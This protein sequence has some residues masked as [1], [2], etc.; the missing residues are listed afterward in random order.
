MNPFHNQEHQQKAAAEKTKPCSLTLH[1][2]QIRELTITFD[3]LSKRVKYGYVYTSFCLSSH[4]FCQY[5]L[6]G[7]DLWCFIH[8]PSWILATLPHVAIAMSCLWTEMVAICPAVASPLDC[9]CPIQQIFFH[10]SWLL[11]NEICFGSSPSASICLPP[12]CLRLMG[13]WSHTASWALSGFH[14]KLGI[15]STSQSWDL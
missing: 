11:E 8:R 2:A 6:N 14:W 1:C 12:I 5:N 13:T 7:A 10:F 3:L 4:H 9:N 15:G